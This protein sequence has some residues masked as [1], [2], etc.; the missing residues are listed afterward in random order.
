VASGT[1]H[2]SG[3]GRGLVLLLALTCG[4][5]VANLYYAQPLLETLADDF[6]VSVATAGLLVTVSQL[7]YV[8]G[9]A[10]LVP[11]GDLRERRGLITVTLAIT[12]VGLGVAAAAPGFVVFGV[13]LG[14]VG[15]TST[16]AQV[17]VP[18]SSSLAA[19]HERGRVVGIVMS[20]LLIG[21]LV[22]RTVSGLIAAAFGWRMVFVVGA[23]GMLV[24]AMT[25]RRALPRVPPTTAGSYGSLLRSVAGLVRSER[26]L[27]ER[28]ALGA[29]AFGCF[30]ALWTALAFLLAGAP[31]HYGNAVI[32]LFGLVGVAGAT[33]A[34]VAGRLSDRG[35]GAQTATA[36][37]LALLISWAALAAGKTSVVAL[38]IGIAL[39]DLGV[40]GLH[41]SN[42]SAIFALRPDARSRLNT[43]YMVSCFLGAS[44]FSALAAAIFDANGWS[45]VCVLGGATAALALVIW[46]LISIRY[47]AL[48]RRAARLEPT[49][50]RSG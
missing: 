10:L 41:I 47:R 16:V 8:V 19:D 35:W 46:A 37:I 42:Q 4:A 36:A 38:I 29:L 14:V 12:A 24:L 45:G 33:A 40:E 6:H 2:Q 3:I 26:V 25:L 49:G 5:A 13:A 34:V 32:G 18:M 20:G 28:M 22:A 27:R 15:V 9:L 43:A 31:Y 7:G 11:V 44:L 39:L 17:I 1:S 50:D 48:S 30:S 21:I 23:V